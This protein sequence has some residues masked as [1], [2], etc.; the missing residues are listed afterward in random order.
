MSTPSNR[1][2]LFVGILFYSQNIYQKTDEKSE[3][4]F[5]DHKRSLALFSNKFSMADNLDPNNYFFIFLLSGY[6][7]AAFFLSVLVI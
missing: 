1:E 3:D 2:N 6:R 5:K 7:S 4:Y